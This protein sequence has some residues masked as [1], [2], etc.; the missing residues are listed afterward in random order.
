M[1]ACSSRGRCRWPREMLPMRHAVS[2]P[3]ARTC[4]DACDGLA[5][6]SAMNDVERGHFYSRGQ[7]RRT[8][9]TL[10]VA[11]SPAP[12]A[13]QVNPLS[14]RQQ[15]PRDVRLEVAERWNKTNAL[16]SSERL[17]IG[18]EQ[19]IRGDVAVQHGPLVIA[20]HVIGSVLAVNS[21]VLLRPTARIDGDLLVVGGDIEGRT[22]ARVDGGI[23]LYRQSLAYHIDNDRLALDDSGG[24]GSSWWQRFDRRR[25]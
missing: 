4:I 25:D 17:E 13:A 7:M 20:G 1:S 15:L 21:D 12:M 18:P 14:D 9:L 16:R 22:A 8:L 24:G 11:V 10:L 5:F 23:R 2:K 19:E 6:P 3:I